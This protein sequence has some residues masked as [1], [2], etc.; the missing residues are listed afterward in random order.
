M[1]T[2]VA[3]P[4]RPQAFSIFGVHAAFAR[5]SGAVITMPPRQEQAPEMP[6]VIL[7]TVE[8]A[9]SQD[10]LAAEPAVKRDRIAVPSFGKPASG[11]VIQV[12]VAAKQAPALGARVLA[13]WPCPSTIREFMLAGN[14]TVS[15]QS[16]KTAFRAVGSCC[17]GRISKPSP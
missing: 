9:V 11:Q 14:A 6:V 15:V 4:K 7:Q 17:R 8:D 16:E 2:F 13:G 12:P 3:H 10:K 1:K 5:R